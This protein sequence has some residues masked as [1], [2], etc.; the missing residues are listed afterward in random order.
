MPWYPKSAALRI[1][2]SKPRQTTNAEGGA[3]APATAT[4]S[5]ISMPPDQRTVMSGHSSGD[6]RG[7][8]TRFRFASLGLGRLR[9]Q[10]CAGSGRS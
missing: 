7:E 6:S 1:D 3:S 2:S 5:F 4:E 8:S 9:R 10:V